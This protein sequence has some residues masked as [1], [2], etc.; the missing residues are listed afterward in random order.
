MKAQNRA[1]PRRCVASAVRALTW[2]EC[3]LRDP[4]HRWLPHLLWQSEPSQV[5]NS[6][7]VGKVPGCLEPE[8]GSV[9]EA[10]SLL[11]SACSPLAVCTLTWADCLWGIRD[12]RWLPHLFRWSEP[13]LVATSPLEGKVPGAW[14]RVC[15]R[16]HVASAVY[17][18][19]FRSLHFHLSK[20]NI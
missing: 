15:H 1:C 8:T 3:F 17:L 9:P 20:L 12:T 16:S 19:T 2:A 18:L 13:S 11:Q 6:P 7:L 5:A 10:V 4:G 14:I